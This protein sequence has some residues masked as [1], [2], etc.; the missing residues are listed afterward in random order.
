MNQPIIVAQDVCFRYDDAA[1]LAVDHVS[2]E[3]AE[4][5]FLAIL[6]RN[7]SGKSTFAKL[8]NALLLPVSG[9]LTRRLLR[10]TVHSAWRTSV[11]ILQ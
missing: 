5:E 3:V 2:L 10:K 8:L 4:G 11:W 1:H 7:G 9:T 6:G